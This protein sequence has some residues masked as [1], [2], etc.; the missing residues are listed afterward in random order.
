[1]D[2]EK[3]MKELSELLTKTGKELSELMKKNEEFLRQEIK[4]IEEILRQTIKVLSI[5]SSNMNI[6]AKVIHIA[7]RK[8][9][10]YEY[11]IKITRI[12]FIMIELN[13]IKYIE[14]DLIA[15]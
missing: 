4:R 12:L 14:L 3:K 11:T 7:N 2:I 5:M 6:V 10:L 15:L 8:L 13:L 9:F 1:M